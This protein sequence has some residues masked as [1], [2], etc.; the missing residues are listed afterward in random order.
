MRIINGVLAIVMLLFAAVQYNDPDG[1]FWAAIYGV[2]ALWCGLAAFRARAYTASPV[3]LLYGL[4]LAG[5]VFGVYWFW[6][7]TPNWWTQE[8]WWNTETAREG[9][10]IMIFTASLCAAGLVAMRARRI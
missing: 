6:P 4:S 10:G 7:T 3:F 9:M 2:G 5:A 1:P 8:V